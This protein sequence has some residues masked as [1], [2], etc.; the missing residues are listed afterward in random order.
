MLPGG[1]FR[2]LFLFLSPV[3]KMSKSISS[4]G[5]LSA[6]VPFHSSDCV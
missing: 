3:N 2:K 1:A 5:R 6:G 4:P